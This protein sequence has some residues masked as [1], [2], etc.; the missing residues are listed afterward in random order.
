MKIIKVNKRHH[1]DFVGGIC[2]FCVRYARIG[3]LLKREGVM[4]KFLKIFALCAVFTFGVSIVCSAQNA[5]P[6]VTAD[7]Y[8]FRNVIASIKE[9]C[10]L[11][12]VGEIDTKTVSLLGGELKKKRFKGLK[13]DMSKSTGLENIENW[14]F[15]NCYCLNSVILPYG[16]KK[17]GKGAFAGDAFP[18][19]IE[20]ITIPDTVQNIGDKA[21]FQCPRLKS[22]IIPDSV[23]IIGNN[24]FDSC[25]GLE[26]VIIPDNVEAI[27]KQVFFSCKNLKSI[28]L[29][30]GVKSIGALAFDYCPNLCEFII[31]EKN[32]HIK[33]VDG[34]LFNNDESSIIC[35]IFDKDRNSYV[36]PDGIESIEEC[37]FH[38]CHFRTITIPDSVKRIEACAFRHC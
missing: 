15:S 38:N 3:A 36:I 35:C 31:D 10:T 37:A 26:S 27:G 19:Q 12:I 16:V 4:K 17:I 18:S 30:S 7:K 24:A 25:H 2:R 28:K 29:G 5:E 14:S 20:S 11:E 13:L 32:E 8:N 6:V 23:K 34:I 9:S 22:I 33:F 21:F 1:D